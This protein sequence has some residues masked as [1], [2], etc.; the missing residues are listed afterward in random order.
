MVRN[1]F[2]IRL[3]LPAMLSTNTNDCLRVQKIVRSI[4]NGCLEYQTTIDNG[5]KRHKCDEANLV[6]YLGDD[7]S[8]KKQLEYLLSHVKI[9]YVIN[10]DEK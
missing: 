8:D 3:G 5:I 4:A 9:S 6:Q 7:D 1:R 2:N 10:D